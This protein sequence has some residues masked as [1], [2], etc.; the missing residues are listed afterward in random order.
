MITPTRSM[1]SPSVPLAT[2][3]EPKVAQGRPTG[4]R[5][6]IYVDISSIDNAT[7]RVI[8]P[9]RL[10]PAHAPSRAR[11]HLRAR[12]VVVSMTRPNLNAVALITD[13]L[14]GAIGSTGFDVLR[15]TSGVLPEW[16]YYAV[17]S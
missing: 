2:I 5:D 12:D 17:Q 7:K 13:E 14:S 4:S 10:P 8:D 6:F 16:I 11:Q 3:T 15:A 1:P 9:K